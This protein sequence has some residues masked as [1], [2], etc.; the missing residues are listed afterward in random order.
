MTVHTPAT[1]QVGVNSSEPL[2]FSVEGEESLSIVDDVVVVVPTLETQEKKKKKISLE[3]K[4]EEEGIKELGEEW[5]QCNPKI[6]SCSFLRAT[7]KKASPPL[8]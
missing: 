1:I 4:E 3:N 2:S 8:C 7:E 5:R 6:S